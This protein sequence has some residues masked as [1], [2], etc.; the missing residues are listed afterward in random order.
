MEYVRTSMHNCQRRTESV[1]D[2]LDL[3]IPYPRN[4]FSGISIGLPGT[5][6]SNM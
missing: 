2:Y 5:V 3:R 4:P 1:D 6:W